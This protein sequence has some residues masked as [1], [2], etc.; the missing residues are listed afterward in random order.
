VEELGGG[1]FKSL[2]WLSIILK[3]RSYF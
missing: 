3:I 2:A 1:V